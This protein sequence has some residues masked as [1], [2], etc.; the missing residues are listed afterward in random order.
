[1]IVGLLPTKE[2]PLKQKEGRLSPPRST[3]LCWLGPLFIQVTCPPIPTITLTGL[4]AKSTMVT[5]AVLGPPG[6]TVTERLVQQVLIWRLRLGRVRQFVERNQVR[7]E[8]RGY[9]AEVETVARHCHYAHRHFHRAGHRHGHYL[10]PSGCV[11]MQF[12]ML[13]AAQ[14]LKHLLQVLLE[15]GRIREPR[16]SL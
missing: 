14:L 12:G 4:N 16:Q 10:H 8:L 1:M 15:T 6:C 5:V 7:H 3:T 13:M 9:V 11:R 2:R